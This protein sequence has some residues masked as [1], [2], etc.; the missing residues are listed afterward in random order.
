MT[1]RTGTQFSPRGMAVLA[2]VVYA[3]V[4]VALLVV[5]GSELDKDSVFPVRAEKSSV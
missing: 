5:W 2:A 3:V 1:E 4:A